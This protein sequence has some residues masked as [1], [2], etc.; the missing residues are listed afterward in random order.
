MTGKARGLAARMAAAGGGESA[1]TPKP[2]EPRG[3]A[4]RKAEVRTRPVRITVDLEPLDH[5]RL[6]GLRRD[7]EERTGL[8]SVAAAEI[9]RALLEELE[10]SA[11]L[12]DAVAGRIIA[13]DRT[14]RS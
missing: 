13:R 11:H 1:G 3:A 12:L 5:R 4:P 10:D 7:L 8:A 14:R 6:Q 9:M 2:E